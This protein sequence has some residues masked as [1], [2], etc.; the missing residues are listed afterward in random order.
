MCEKISIWEFLSSRL[1][2]S[3]NL[4]NK[5]TSSEFRSSSLLMS[6]SFSSN[7]S[8]SLRRSI[9][10]C[11]CR[12]KEKLTQLNDQK[13]RTIIKIKYYHGPWIWSEML[14]TWMNIFTIYFENLTSF[15]ARV[16]RLPQ[17]RQTTFGETFHVN[18]STVDQ[19]LSGSCLS[20][21]IAASND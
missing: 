5:I 9:L 15:H 2:V 20:M 21:G 7:I 13:C 14:R 3:W 12:K 1:F 16:G 19:S 10:H 6:W 17:G 4:K 8:S 18:S 11:W